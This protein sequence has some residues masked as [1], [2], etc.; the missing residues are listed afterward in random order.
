MTA[1]R[2][3]YNDLHKFAMNLIISTT[4]Y[5]PDRATPGHGLSQPSELQP[6]GGERDRGDGRGGVRRAGGGR[7]GEGHAGPPADDRRR[8]GRKIRK[9]VTFGRELHLLRLHRGGALAQK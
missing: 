7:A 3:R 2:T 6:A 4:K 9:D 8:T 1:R 5:F